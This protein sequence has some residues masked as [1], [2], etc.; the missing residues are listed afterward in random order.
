MATHYG[1][2]ATNA[3]NVATLGAAERNSSGGEALRV[4]R[5]S[6]TLAVASWANNDVLRLGPFRAGEKVNGLLSRIIGDAT[7]DLGDDI[8]L[9]WAYVDGTGTADPDA[10]IA[11]TFDCSAATIDVLGAILADGTVDDGI[12]EPPTNDRDWWLTLTVIDA[13]GEAAGDVY[14][15]IAVENFR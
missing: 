15:Q 8:D 2:K 12:Y 9:G 6:F 3:N 14:F 13:T 1:T 5:E 4:H 11:G 7:V 10:F